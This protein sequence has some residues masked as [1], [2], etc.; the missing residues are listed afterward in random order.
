MISI[1]SVN[2]CVQIR[3][4][5]NP[6]IS[7]YELKQFLNLC[8][9]IAFVYLRK[10]EQSGRNFTYQFGISLEDFALD[11]IAELFIE[12]ENGVYTKF[13]NYFSKIDNL[14]KLSNEDLLISLRRLIFSQVNHHIY[15]TNKIFDPILGKII[16]NIKL[17]LLNHSLLHLNTYIN[18]L[19]IELKN[20][21]YKEDFN[22]VM[23][24][25]IL[26]IELRSES[27]V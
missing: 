8:H 23:P 10:K 18:Q 6:S 3:S 14:S 4:I 5:L 25:E 20:Y 22:P 9:K 7:R 27:V 26:E 15:R 13:T 11:C 2:T 16:R 24:L 1:N 19:I 21:S 12:N 17:A